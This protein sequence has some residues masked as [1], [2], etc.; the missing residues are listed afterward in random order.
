MGELLLLKNNKLLSKDL[1]QNIQLGSHS[2]LNDNKFVSIIKELNYTLIPLGYVVI[3][4]I[5]RLRQ[6]NLYVRTNLERNS[7]I[8]VKY[9]NNVTNDNFRDYK[10][11]GSEHIY[12]NQFNNSRTT[13]DSFDDTSEYYSND[14]SR[15]TS[16][17][18]VSRTS[19][20]YDPSSSSTGPIFL[21]ISRFQII[22]LGHG[23]PLLDIG[24][25]T[26]TRCD[27]N[28]A[29]IQIHQI[30]EETHGAREYAT[31]V[32]GSTFIEYATKGCAYKACCDDERYD[33]I[34]L[35]TG[36][37]SYNV[38]SD[39]VVKYTDFMSQ[40]LTDDIISAN[41]GI[42]GGRRLQWITDLYA[43][44]IKSIYSK[45]ERDRCLKLV[46]DEYESNHE[47]LNQPSLHERYKTSRLVWEDCFQYI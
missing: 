19:R 14:S 8:S 39:L 21:Y 10:K 46:D 22:R 4:K 20:K 23:D 9:N 42:R 33:L 11:S 41:M 36:V 16:Y 28:M 1:P 30:G 7:R 26:D 35:V 32:C 47:S 37:P 5:Y 40:Y 18:N 38:S 25:A 17:N 12:I 31:K 2:S 34:H 6:N 27:Q 15:R 29:T 44:H 3:I 45:V 13:F 24:I 43:S